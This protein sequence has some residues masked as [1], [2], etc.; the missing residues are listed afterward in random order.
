M[1]LKKTFTSIINEAQMVKRILE[2]KMQHATMNPEEEQAYDD[3]MKSWKYQKNSNALT[4]TLT[5]PTHI[6]KTTAS[7]VI[8]TIKL[9]FSDN[10]TFV[11][12][13][14]KNGA[15]PKPPRQ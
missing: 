3:I 8:K 11:I 15:T 9:E 14:Q 13:N 1:N 6:D 10:D 2:I 5:V 7:K 4:H 12:K